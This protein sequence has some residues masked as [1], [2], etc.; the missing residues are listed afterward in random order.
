MLL[1]RGGFQQDLLKV[2]EVL[3]VHIAAHDV[4]ARELQARMND[5]QLR[6]ERLEARLR[7]AGVA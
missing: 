1:T 7:A 4:I 5:L 6:V 3:D 2:R